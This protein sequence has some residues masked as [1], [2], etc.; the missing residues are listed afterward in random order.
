VVAGYIKLFLLYG[1]FME[2]STLVKIII[3]LL[4]L[5]AAVILSAAIIFPQISKYNGGSNQI[6]GNEEELKNNE[7][8]TAEI[9]TAEIDSAEID[10]AEI[11]EPA[12]NNTYTAENN[13]SPENKIDEEAEKANRIEYLL[14][15][16]DT[17]ENIEEYLELKYGNTISTEIGEY[18]LYYDVRIQTSISSITD[19]SDVS[20]NVDPGWVTD[21]IEELANSTDKENRAKAERVNKQFKDFMTDLAEHICKVIPNKKIKGRYCH[22]G[23][24]LYPNLKMG[25]IMDIV[26]PWQN[27]RDAEYYS[28]MGDDYAGDYE[29]FDFYYDKWEELRVLSPIELYDTIMPE[30]TIYWYGGAYHKDFLDFLY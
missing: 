5:N 26:M 22:D 23:G 3:V 19:I 10:S 7:T 2:K 15:N 9:K 13:K 24:Y 17:E 12:A 11:G 28:A 14:N 6:S 18:K 21:D 16:L 4:I 20:V 8:E 29:K 1:G 30:K 25:G 27:Y